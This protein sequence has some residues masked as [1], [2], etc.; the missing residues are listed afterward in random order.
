MAS[1]EYTRGTSFTDAQAAA[2]SAP[3]LVS[4]EFFDWNFDGSTD[5]GDRLRLHFDSAV[6]LSPTPSLALALAKLV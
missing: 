2:P 5:V 3:R 1:T 4:A 6:E